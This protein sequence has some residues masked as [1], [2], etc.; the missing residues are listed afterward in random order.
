MQDSVGG[1]KPT[2]S[3]GACDKLQLA[4]WLARVKAWWAHKEPTRQVLLTKFFFW[5]TLN[6]WVYCVNPWFL[7]C[8]NLSAACVSFIK[9]NLSLFCLQRCVLLPFVFLVVECRLGLTKGSSACCTPGSHLLCCTAAAV[10]FAYPFC[11]ASVQCDVIIFIGYW[12]TRNWTCNNLVLHAYV[13]DYYMFM[14]NAVLHS[15][16]WTCNNHEHML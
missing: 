12:S 7:F 11:D 8:M 16:D 2:C 4:D 10:N 9:F 14:I 1:V 5:W 3:S 15:H 13:A 6:E